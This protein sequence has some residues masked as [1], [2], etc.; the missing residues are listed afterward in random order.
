MAIDFLE[1]LRNQVEYEMY[2]RYKLDLLLYG[3]K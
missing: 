1:K 2:R 3:A